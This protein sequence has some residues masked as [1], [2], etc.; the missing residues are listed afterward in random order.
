MEAH[1]FF[2]TGRVG[3]AILNC[4]RLAKF[5]SVSPL[6]F[7]ALPLDEV[8]EHMKWTALVVQKGDMAQPRE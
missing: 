8:A 5:Y 1:G 4:Y 6:E 7:L 2:H 3:D